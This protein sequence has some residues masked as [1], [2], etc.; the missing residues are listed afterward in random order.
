M[1][2]RSKTNS[3]LAS[4]H[5]MPCERGTGSFRIY[6]LSNEL[7]KAAWIGSP[8]PHSDAHADNSSQTAALTSDSLLRLTHTTGRLLTTR[9]SLGQPRSEKA[10]VL[11]ISMIPQERRYQATRGQ[12][13][14]L[15][16]AT[17]RDHPTYGVQF[18]PESIL[19][20]QGEALLT[21]FL[22]LSMN[23]RA[24]GL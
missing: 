18:H 24:R 22:R 8:Q 14:H 3:V 7:L 12:G 13:S 11:S 19:T 2:P 23:V 6:V 21:N 20:Q 1:V 16:S 17:H 4:D 15:R 10:S 5:L 9:S